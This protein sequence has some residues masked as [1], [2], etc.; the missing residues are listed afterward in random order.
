[1]VT[2]SFTKFRQNA[3]AYFSAVE[4]G[5]TIQVLRHGKVVAKIIPTTK[6]EFSWKAPHS[7]LMIPGA[8]LSE[9]IL[10]ERKIS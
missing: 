4:N 5:E 6:K 3:T 9:A 10:N 8:S 7:P 2:V 1:M